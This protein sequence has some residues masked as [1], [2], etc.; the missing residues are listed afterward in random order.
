M[1][2]LLI[3]LPILLLIALE[4]ISQTSKDTVHLPIEQ[5]KKAISI[6]E[7]GKVQQ[8]ELI[9][10]KKA[11]QI[12]ENRLILKDS[13]IYY[14]SLKDKMYLSIIEGYKKNLSNSNQIVSNL[15]HNLKIEE[16]QTR[17]QKSLKWVFV[18]VGFAG[19]FLIAK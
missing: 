14:N 4:G 1:K 11:L 6:I 8:E 13:V 19:G 16:R 12:A 7:V 2:K 3:A 15:E 10:T 17:I 9:L 18:A 5:V